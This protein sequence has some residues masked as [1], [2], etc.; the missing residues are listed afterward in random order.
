MLHAHTP[1]DEGAW[2]MLAE[3][4]QMEAGL[5]NRGGHR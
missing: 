5:H 3:H 1:N 2:H 4:L